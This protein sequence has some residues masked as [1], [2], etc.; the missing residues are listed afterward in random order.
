MLLFSHIK[1]DKYSAKSRSSSLIAVKSCVHIKAKGRWRHTKVFP[2]SVVVFLHL[3]IISAKLTDWRWYAQRRVR[4]TTAHLVLSVPF[5]FYPW[6]TMKKQQHITFPDCASDKLGLTV[7][8]YHYLQ[9]VGH[10]CGSSGMHREG[11]GSQWHSWYGLFHPGFILDKTWKN[12][13][14]SLSLIV[15]L[16]SRVRV[17]LAYHFLQ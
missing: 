8:S 4:V 14:T 7:T 17:L 11:S 10:L 5:G 3:L 13:N 16:I 2:I 12:S 6:Q 9:E 1:S 15:S